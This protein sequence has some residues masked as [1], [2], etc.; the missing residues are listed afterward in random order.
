MA[1]RTLGRVA[2]ACAATAALTA[3]TALPAAQAH[4][5]HD[6][7]YYGYVK[8]CQY[9]RYAD[10]DEDYRGEYSVR[11]ERSYDDFYLS[12]NYRCHQSRV[13]SGWVTVR[14]LYTPENTRFYGNRYQ[15]FYLDRGDYETVRFTYRADDGY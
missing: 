2:A 4:P 13:R 3:G 7:N 6:R 1:S 10:D 11:G 14:V 9:V 8:V 12:E 5:R 15:R